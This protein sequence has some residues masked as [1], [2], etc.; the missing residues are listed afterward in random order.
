[1]ETESIKGFVAEVDPLRYRGQT[2]NPEES[3]GI[4]ISYIPKGSRVLDVGCG[5]GSVSCLIRDHCESEVIGLEPNSERAHAA[6]SSGLQVI[7]E[8]FAPGKVEGFGKFDVIVFADVLEHLVNPAEALDLAKTLLAP[9]GCVVASVPNVAHW[10][11]RLDLLLGRFDYRELGIMD[12][13]HLR[14]FTAETLEKLFAASGFRIA[15]YAGSAGHWMSDYHDRRPWKW[16][17]SHRRQQLVRLGLKQWPGLF[18]CQ[19]V[20]KAVRDR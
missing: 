12:A 13:T 20:V 19:H 4:L 18:A 15:N 7:N 8:L 14:W 2:A 3:A 17:S 9:G 5:T 1:M 11:V 16:M 6:R 10:S